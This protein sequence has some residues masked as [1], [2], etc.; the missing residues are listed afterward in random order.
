MVAGWE[1]SVV[2]I[3]EDVSGLR[4]TNRYLQNRHGDVNY[5]IGNGVAEE[6]TRMTHAHE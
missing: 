2:G 4:S 5:S 6:L 3:D 1:G